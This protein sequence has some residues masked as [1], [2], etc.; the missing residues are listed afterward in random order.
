LLKS[1]SPKVSRRSALKLGLL[2]TS[3]GSG[4]KLLSGLPSIEGLSW[5]DSS[6][7][8]RLSDQQMTDPKRSSQPA[9][10]FL[11]FIPEAWKIVEP[12][13]PFV[14]GYHVDAIAEH[15]QAISD[16]QLQNLII[17]IPPRHTKSTFVGVLWPAWEWTVNPH[18]QWLCASYREALAIRDGVKMRRLVMSSWYQERWG[19]L[20]RLTGDQNEKRRFENDAAG[21]R[22]SIGVG[23]GTGEGG[24]RLVCLGYNS[25]ITTSAGRL[26]IGQIVERK[27]PVKVLSFDHATDRACW[28]D[29]EAYESGP[30]R[31]SVRITLSYGV[32]LEATDDHPVYVGGRGYVRAADLRPN[33]R[34]LAHIPTVFALRPSDPSQA[35]QNG[36][37]RRAPDVLQQG[38]SSS[39][40]C[41][42]PSALGRG[43]VAPD[44]PVVCGVRQGSPALSVS[45]GEAGGATGLLQSCL[46]RYRPDRREQSDVPGRTRYAALPSLRNAERS[47][48]VSGERHDARQ[49]QCCVP[50]FVP[51]S[52]QP[53]AGSAA[54]SVLVLR[55]CDG[56][57]PL[58]GRP[59]GFLLADVREPCPLS[60]HQGT[61]E[62]SVRAR[63]CGESVSG[64]VQSDSSGDQAPRWEP[65]PSLLDDDGGAWAGAVGAS[66]RLR[67]DAQRRDEPDYI[68]QVV[69][70]ED[71]RPAGEPGRVA[72][73]AVVSIERIPPLERVYNLR[74][75][76]HH[77][78]FAA[79][80][81]VHNCDDPLSAEQAESDAYRD[82][83]NN[84][85]DSTFS[86]RGND[87]RTVARVIV[88][89]RLHDED[90]TGHLLEKMAAGGAQFDHLILPAEY[91]PT[92]QIC[93]AGLGEHDIRTEPGQPLS[94]ERYGPEQL[95]QLKID[96]GT[97]QRVAGQLQQRP[98]PAGGNVFQRSWWDGKNR[99]D[100]ADETLKH[101]IVGRWLFIDTAYK[102]KD[103]SD[104][105]A[106]SVMELLPDYRLLWREVWN[107][108]LTFPYLLPRI[109]TTAL[110]ANGDGKLQGVIVEDKGS[111]TSAV[112]SLQ[113]GSPSWLAE[114][115]QPFNPTGSK[116][117]RAQQASLWCARNCLLMPEPSDAAPWLHDATEQL[118]K[119]PTAAHDDIVDTLSMGLIFLEHLLA[120][121]HRARMGYAA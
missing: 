92:V 61:W 109:E 25:L 16:G 51:Q 106:C 6:V 27:M 105:T 45:H 21:Y 121:G 66:H 120:E 2:A 79:G 29:V 98:S 89:Q 78:Y 50:T 11:N 36:T 17:N 20:Y 41:Q 40:R 77:N 112:Q 43:T 23:T 38:V 33:D 87:P 10:T 107:E 94:P 37:A 63:S 113:F 5:T 47:E 55:R 28:G 70:R 68:V 14:S 26:P 9:L 91:E 104:Y 111:G 73:A 95:E 115:I 114:L 19:G 35:F 90:T 18:L 44:G 22:V 119:F 64:R 24:H 39:S 1:S 46:S 75:A 72:E 65:L 69:S 4:S 118:F 74:V 7:F 103:T 116:V 82:A 49:L 42:G 8:S 58:A 84:W 32:T 85:I 67:Q 101:K 12:S 86:T 100:A 15:L 59:A 110:A 62:S 80:I 53:Q 3:L 96:L 93:L 71:A 83:A 54:G 99:Y 97:P 48:V 56:N 60:A 81:L 34:V 30:G 57:T 13:T 102:D 117:Y 76:P 52:S 88:M 108:R 31:P